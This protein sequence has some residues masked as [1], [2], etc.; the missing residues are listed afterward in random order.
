MAKT[1]KELY[2][3]REMAIDVPDTNVAALRT[4][5]KKA[6]LSGELPGEA[7]AWLM[8]SKGA[9]AAAAEPK[10]KKAAKGK[11]KEAEPAAPASVP[12]QPA[13]KAAMD[14]SQ[15]AWDSLAAQAH[16]RN[17][18]PAQV[19]PKPKPGMFDPTSQDIQFDPRSK[20]L[21]GATGLD[22][23]D[24]P[25]A[26]NVDVKGGKKQGRLSRIFGQKPQA[27]QTGNAINPKQGALSRLFGKGGPKVKGNTADDDATSYGTPAAP[28]EVDPVATG[29]AAKANSFRK[30]Q[31]WVSGMDDYGPPEAST[32]GGDVEDPTADLK[33]LGKSYAKGSGVDDLDWDLRNAPPS[34]PN[35][36]A[37]SPMPTGPTVANPKSASKQGPLQQQT[38]KK[39]TAARGGSAFSVPPLAV[40]PPLP[41]KAAPKPPSAKPTVMGVP[42]MPQAQEPPVEPPIAARKKSSAKR[43]A[44]K[45]K[46][47]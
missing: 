43:K 24:A 29:S 20:G 17:P 5:V 12:V 16:T 31:D 27:Q 21:G 35:S 19:V 41:R 25:Q 6:I 3:L 14:K 1:L 10:A 33:A 22:D 34:Q 26:A 37:G 45:G 40:P 23:L 47:S 39:A 18:G 4:V 32:V 9:A 13:A 46:K 8:A 42:P 15:S 44:A 28:P 38:P 36:T 2:G 30:G 7:L 11:G